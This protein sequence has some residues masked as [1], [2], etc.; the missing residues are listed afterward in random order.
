MKKILFF[1]LI[2]V[3][4]FQ[5]AFAQQTEVQIKGEISEIK[6]GAVLLL[7]QKPSRLDTLARAVIG[8]D[9]FLLKADL[10]EACV[11]SMVL[12]GYGGGFVMIAEFSKAGHQQNELVRYQSV[13]SKNSAEIA[14]MKMKI[15][16]ASKERRFKTMSDLNKELTQI[17]DNAQGELLF[18]LTCLQ[19][20][21]L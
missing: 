13:V 10:D 4:V 9:G 20:V 7:V 16:E 11:A 1:V 19:M 14:S 2:N 5:F 15:E 12:D 18:L 21:L 6:E 8:E 3:F 17:L